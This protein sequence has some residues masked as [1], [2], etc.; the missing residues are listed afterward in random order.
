MSTR[1]RPLTKQEIMQAFA[2]CEG[3]EIPAIVGVRQLAELL[4]MSPKTIY[5]WV[6]KGRFDGAY[7][8]RGKHLRFWRDRA[9]YRFFNGPDWGAHGGR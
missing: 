4:G 8:R 1:K 2:T 3:R 9:I 6:S 7:R 5:E